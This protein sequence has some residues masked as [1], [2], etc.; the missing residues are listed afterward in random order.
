MLKAVSVA[1]GIGASFVAGTIYGKCCNI[2]RTPIKPS[3]PLFGIVSA[4]DSI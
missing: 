2:D 3:I 1:I 4:A